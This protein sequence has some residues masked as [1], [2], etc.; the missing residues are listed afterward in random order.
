MAQSRMNDWYVTAL[1]WDPGVRVDDPTE[2]VPRPRASW[3]SSLR[4]RLAFASGGSTPFLQILPEQGRELGISTQPAEGS[5]FRGYAS[6]LIQHAGV[7]NTSWQA[8][9]L[10]CGERRDRPWGC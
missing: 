4:I 6:F 9:I 1:N 10:F 3:H 8:T 2:L 5:G 7:Y